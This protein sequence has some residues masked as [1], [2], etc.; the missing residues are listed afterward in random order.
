MIDFV[1]T[2]PHMGSWLKDAVRATLE[3]DPFEALNDLEIL[4]HLIRVR[5]E[6]LAAGAIEGADATYRPGDGT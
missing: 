3:P 2:H 4:N 6:A 1:M 5:C